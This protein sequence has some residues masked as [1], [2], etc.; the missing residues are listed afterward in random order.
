MKNNSFF[1]F[2]SL[3]LGA[4]FV[5]SIVFSYTLGNFDGISLKELNRDYLSKKELSFSSLPLSVQK[6]YIDRDRSNSQIK[7][8]KMI[9][10]FDD[11]GN[12]L[13][14][15]MGEL[16]EFVATLQNRVAYLERENIIIES[17]KSELIKIVE[18]EKSKK[19]SDQKALL[20]NN[21]N[22]INE[23]EKQHYKNISELTEK[24]N[25]LYRENIN[26]SQ[27][28]NK[29]DDSNKEN[30]AFAQQQIDEEKAI[31]K[32]RELELQNSYN[33]KTASWDSKNRS[34]KSQYEKTSFALQSQRSTA[35]L[36]LGKKD[37]KILSLENRINE[38]MVERNKI[39]TK[40]TE[41]ML[42]IERKNSEKLKEFND[43]VKSSSFEKDIIKQEYQKTLKRVQKKQ[44]STLKAQEAK[45]D[46]LTQ[47]LAKQTRKNA[48]A[49]SHSK[50]F[51]LKKDIATDAK[52][53]TIAKENMA[54]LKEM[55]QKIESLKSELA[56][57]NKGNKNSKSELDT[58]KTSLMLAK[59]RI[60]QLE[61]RAKNLQIDKKSVDKEVDKQISQNEI[62]HNKNYKILNEKIAS[63]EMSLKS[64]LNSSDKALS[65]LDG[66]KAQLA[67]RLSISM[68]DSEEKKGRIKVLEKR[69]DKLK[70]G[71]YEKLSDAKESFDELKTALSLREKEYQK[72]KDNLKINAFNQKRDAAKLKQYIS[73]IDELKSEARE[74]K[75]KSKLEKLADVECGDMLS[76]N[77]LISSTCRAKVDE[78]LGQYDETTF[79]EV[80]P[81]VGSGGFAA[82]KKAGRDRE[83]GIAKSEIKR[84]TRLANIGLARDRAKEGGELIRKRFGDD[85]KISYSVESIEAEDKR[86]FVI[87]A[88][89]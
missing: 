11:N 54:K 30:I 62:K 51:I 48:S 38:M 28:L 76:G 10:V 12:P 75:T 72:A 15:D 50:K 69:I 41:A 71:E 78:F 59:D 67:K 81:I 46:A 82:L 40:N 66:E 64:K 33:L 22:K 18:Y 29:K 14:E 80:V 24:I 17:D 58:S 27:E 37:Q 8:T 79:F 49:E 36:E 86:G 3:L 88:Y 52:M 6:R 53:R 9:R 89:R 35:I 45:I 20:T 70:V 16:K 83:L 73:D 21:L 47:K 84:L 55:K 4:L 44:N 34:I 32:Q 26:L 77:F 1:I 85:V 39:L 13:V 25:N 43:I 60:L 63:L 56:Y 7:E 31:S 87:N 23:A 19:S 2:L 42:K 74:A 68:R 61:E 5:G 57:I 65:V